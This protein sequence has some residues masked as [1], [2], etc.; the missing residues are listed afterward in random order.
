MRGGTTAWGQ[1]MHAMVAAF[2]DLATG[3]GHESVKKSKKCEKVPGFDFLT[4]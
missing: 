1:D 4:M 3:K 2:S